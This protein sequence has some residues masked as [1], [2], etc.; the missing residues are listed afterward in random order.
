[1]DA[2]R[3]IFRAQVSPGRY[4]ELVRRV[5]QTALVTHGALDKLVPLAAV[6]E[7]TADHPNWKLEIYHDLGHIP[8]ME[9]PARW[10]ETVERW[11]AVEPNMAAG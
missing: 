11:L 6:R 4:R 1:M 8:M 5:R 2:A 3:S 9:A 7:A 10:L